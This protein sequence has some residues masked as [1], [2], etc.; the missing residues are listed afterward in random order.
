MRKTQKAKDKVEAEA[1]ADEVI[2]EENYLNAEGYSD[3]LW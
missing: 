2:N 1:K 3:M